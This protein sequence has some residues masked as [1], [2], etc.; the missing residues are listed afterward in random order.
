VLKG[1][2]QAPKQQVLARL[3]TKNTA[4]FIYYITYKAEVLETRYQLGKKQQRLI[5]SSKIA[6]ALT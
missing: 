2:L 6:Q 5:Q 1:L 4:L 3:C